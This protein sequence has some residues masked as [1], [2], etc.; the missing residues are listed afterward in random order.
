MAKKKKRNPEKML[1]QVQDS[2]QA[3]P[4]A[5]EEHRQQ[6]RWGK[7]F[8]LRYVSGPMLKLMNRAL[9]SRRYKGPEGQKLKQTD[10][11]RRHLQQKQAARKQVQ[12]MMRG[13]DPAEVM[14]QVNAMRRKAGD[15]KKAAAQAKKKSP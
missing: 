14:R 9:G 6:G 7:A 5:I 10:Q 8:M 15:P 4:Y 3:L 2:L 12:E 11:M 13:N 1:R